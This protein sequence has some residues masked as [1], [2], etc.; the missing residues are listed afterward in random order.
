MI[1]KKIEGKKEE[2][3]ERGGV[4]TGKNRTGKSFGIKGMSQKKLFRIT[5]ESSISKKKKGK[6]K[7]LHFVFTNS[8]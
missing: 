1:F 2:R 6:K 4:R 8:K 3:K 5:T 7:K